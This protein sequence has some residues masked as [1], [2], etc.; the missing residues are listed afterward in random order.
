MPTVGSQ[1]TA[2]GRP[3]VLVGRTALALTVDF[4]TL[5]LI[6]ATFALSMDMAPKVMVRRALAAERA[7]AA[8]RKAKAARARIDYLSIMLPLCQ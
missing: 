6:S 2:K 7:A 1:P 8:A 4:A 5:A 3:C